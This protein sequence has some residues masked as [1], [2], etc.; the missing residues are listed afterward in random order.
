MENRRNLFRLFWMVSPIG[1]LV[2][3]LGGVMMLCAAETFAQPVEPVL[4]FPEI[5][6]DDTSTYRGYTTRF[7]QDLR[8]NTVQVYL[9]QTSGRTVHVWADAA[10]ESLSFTARDETGRPALLRWGSATATLSEDGV[11]RYLRHT[12]NSDSPVLE[13]GHFVLNTMRLER[14]FQY[15]QKHLA[16]YDAEPFITAELPQLIRNLQQ[17]PDAVR[18]QHLRLL[19]AGS[20]AELERRLVPA[21]TTRERETG[22]VVQ[23]TQPTFDGKNHLSLAFFVDPQEGAVTVSG[24]RVV[25]RSRSGAPLRLDLQIGTD[26]PP[27][28]PLNREEI[29]NADFWLF[30]EQVKAAATS[31]ERQLQF[32]RLS[33]QVASMD[34]MC[35]EE[36]LFAGLPNYATYFGRDMMMS[37][38]MLEPVVRPAILAHVIS[39]VLRKLRENGEVS[40]EEGLGSQAIRENAATY[41]RLIAAYLQQKLSDATIAEKTLAA[42]AGVLGDLQRVTENYHM[43]DDD[44]QLPVLA[45]RYLS[46]ADVPEEQKRVF[47]E[48]PADENGAATR[49]ALLLRNLNY[50]ADASRAYVEDPVPAN[51]IS[52]RRVDEH[53]W[54]AGSWRDSRVGY[55]NGRYAMDIN[56]IWVPQA[57]AALERIMAGLR[58]LGYSPEDLQ[59]AAP[60][61]QNS[62]VLDYAAHPDKLH[63]AVTI[64]EGS[65]RHFVVHFSPE[66]VQQ[67]VQTRLA[68][69]PAVERKYWEGVLAKT[70]ADPKGVSF[71]AISL[72]ENGKPIPVAHTDVATWLFLEDL[73]AQIV[74]GKTTPEAV[75]QQLKLFVT[76]YPVGLFIEN[77]GPVV[78]NDVYADPEVWQNFENDRYHSP[79]VVWGR[80][81]NLLFLGLAKQIQSAAGVDNGTD[82]ASYVAELRKILDQ[83][84][85]AVKA[86]GLKHNEL[87]SYRIEEDQLRPARY[88]S[89]TD[90]Q[91][92]NL[93]DLAV[94]YL[95][96]NL[97]E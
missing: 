61:L 9:Q 90:I 45:A 11:T 74:A 42:A 78:A 47:L 30:Y 64:W 63:R 43:V 14:D 53:H 59:Q 91:L 4:E 40:H 56:V 52:F 41:N 36:K 73:T 44:F 21:I 28:H 84:V 97:R 6:V 7:Y 16:P 23:V 76:R 83:N 80:E 18:Q 50:A 32:R 39:S 70:G 92:W 49:L 15:F 55:A 1:L 85:A 72:D 46:R 93:T 89:T 96:A 57:L 5:G 54:H 95:L 8:Q 31:P 51:L 81:V 71:L 65:A 35:F 2:V 29:F 12:L 3:L 26:S 37:A 82:L 24:S 69:L 75:L 58:E 27:L 10:N 38:L 33:R 88:G 19:N 62:L 13:L 22:V 25:I 60:V 79:R 94:Q 77:I 67:R 68:A 66:E 34:L 86:S 48:S 17:L 20:I 87:W